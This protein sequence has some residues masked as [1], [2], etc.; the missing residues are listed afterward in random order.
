MRVATRL[1]AGELRD[2]KRIY[3]IITVVLALTMTSYLVLTAYEQYMV[4]ITRDGL[5]S[6]ITGD[7]MVLEPQVSLREAYGGAPRFPN[8]K[9]LEQRLGSTGAYRAVAR[10]TVQGVLQ[11]PDTPP[12]GAIFRGI[13]PARD[14]DVFDLKAK[15]VEG[16]YFPPGE[17]YT[18]G[19]VGR[20][21]SLPPPVAVGN[22]STTEV[23]TRYA[24]AYPVIVGKAFFDS[25]GLEV[26][27]L[28]RATVQTGRG[29]ADYTFVNLRVIGAYEI[30]LPVMEQIVHFAH[31]DSLREITGWGA[32]AA[33][34]VAVKSARTAK[35]EEPERVAADLALLAPA[36]TAYTWHDVLVY[37]SG[38]L[39][40]TIN[41]LLYGTMTVT[42]ILAA[43]AIKY[44][45]DSIILRKT[46][47]I[48]SLK[49]FGARDR[50]VLQIFLLQA[51]VIG[52]AAGALGVASGYAVV[53][54]ARLTGL[55]T[56]FLAGSAI[57][58]DFVITPE[59]VVLTVLLPVALSLAASV[60]P[61]ERA[62]KL[63]PVEAL[64]RGELAL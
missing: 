6:T 62:A 4:Q 59:A 49:A 37:V 27:A 14:E 48:G 55:R 36:R 53:A 22:V 1:A 43:A 2:H 56:E 35:L 60:V 52:L 46:R 34:E 26:G 41:I 23:T 11:G 13:D 24:D 38:T 9:E 30:G 47:E 20:L 25:R 28:L 16:S 17:R 61:A 5:A 33:T 18:Q 12:E 58:V 32:E 31:I 40:D 50:V 45:M 15:V 19:T 29:G 57:K 64:R 39:M 51:L 3:A 8:S 44:V 10:L 7:G 54:W 63:A 21:V 42:L